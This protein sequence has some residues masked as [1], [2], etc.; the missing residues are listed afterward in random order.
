M[1]NS[2]G[3]LFWSAFRTARFVLPILALATAKVAYA[4]GEDSIPLSS[5]AVI[6]GTAIASHDGGSGAWYN[7]AALGGLARNSVQVSTSIYTLALRRIG[8]YLQARLPWATAESSPGSADF[9]SVP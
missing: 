5:D 9:T 2:I 6:A 4:G 1:R 3:F 7:P 8:G